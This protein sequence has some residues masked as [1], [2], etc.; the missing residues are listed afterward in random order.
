MLIYNLMI[1]MWSN[2]TLIFNM[3]TESKAQL[4]NKLIET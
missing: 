4:R 1:Y 2:E 3:N